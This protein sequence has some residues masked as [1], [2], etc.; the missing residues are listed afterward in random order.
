MNPGSTESPLKL[1][2]V[3]PKDASPT[4][5]RFIMLSLVIPPSIFMP[6]PPVSKLTPPCARTLKLS[7]A[8]EVKAA[9]CESAQTNAPSLVA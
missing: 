7:L 9:F 6:A 4:P 8:V 3:S 5:V 2:P 1:E